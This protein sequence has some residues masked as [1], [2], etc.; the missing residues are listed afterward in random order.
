[1]NELL[2]PGQTVRTESSGLTCTVE[3]F[4]GGGGQGE[5]YQ[6]NL[7]A[8]RVALK[9]Y[10]PHYLQQDSRLRERLEMAVSSGPP[11]DRFLWPME[12]VSGQDVPGFGYVMPL[13]EPRFKGILDMMKRQVE[14]GFRALAT[15]GFELSHN[16]LQLH[17]K[18][19]CYRDIN[20]NNV[21]FDPETGEVRICDNDNVDVN[22][23]PGI[24]GG[25]P[26]FMAPEIVRGEAMPSTDTDLFSLAVLLFYMLMVHH[27]LEGKRESGIAILDQQAMTNL[28]GTDPVFIF[29]PDDDSNRPVPGCHDNALAFW[30]LYPQFLRDLFTKAFTNGIRDPS[31]GRVREGE[32]RP[33]MVCLRDSVIYCPH[34]TRENFYDVEAL[35]ASAGKPPACWSCTKAI[36]LPPRMR[37]EKSIVM[38]NADSELFPHHIDDRQRYDF[39]RPVAAMAQHPSNPN[40]WGL[41]NLSQDKWV[42]TTVDGTIRDVEPGRTVTLG[43]GT[44]INFG[45]AEGEIR[46]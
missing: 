38:L 32:W 40:I 26:R 17:S 23:K 43:V 20:F 37:I 34:C 10:F 15:A 28:Y 7:D 18:G 25:T 13:R 45:T 39:S 24:V 41:K 35:K 27:P 1:M 22:G 36:R 8:E 11:S 9:W 16:Y 30:P 33:A 42:I 5:V 19:M 12:L 31:Y 46:V 6:A 4:L 29:D 14:P 2:K 3:Q 44:K 21:F